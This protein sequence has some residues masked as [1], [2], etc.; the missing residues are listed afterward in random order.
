M[1]EIVVALGLA[2]LEE[3][4]FVGGMVAGFFLYQSLK[5]LVRGGWRPDIK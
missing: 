5:L 1:A 2:A 3:A 4:F